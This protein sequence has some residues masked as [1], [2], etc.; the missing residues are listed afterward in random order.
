MNLSKNFTLAELTIS[1]EAAR[2]GLKNQPNADQ[3]ESLSLLCENVLQPL[4]D[5]VKKPLVVSSGFRSVTINR[6][7]GGS[8]S[9][10]HCKGQ[11]V[12]F[13]IPGMTVADT[14]ALIRKMNLPFDQLI[15]EFGQWVHV[16]YGPRN[17]KQVL[18]ARHVGGKTV[19]SPME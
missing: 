5:R 9:S 18:K 17:R 15:E 14:V 4:R 16:S 10:Q 11:A 7:I 3:I 1:Q 13:T 2:S 6:R 19:Y 8:D 12:D